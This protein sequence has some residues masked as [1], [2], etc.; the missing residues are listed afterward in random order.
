MPDTR[1]KK[2]AGNSDVTTVDT[3]VDATVDPT[4]APTVDATVV[5]TVVSTEVT[6]V[7]TGGASP[8]SEMTEVSSGAATM[9]A[10]V[11]V[12]EQLSGVLSSMA[13]K[14]E[15]VNFPT[16]SG[17]EDSNVTLFVSKVDRI[18]I[19]GA[20]REEQVLD[21]LYQELTGSAKVYL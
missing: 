15:P 14:N 12:M 3:T 7:S 17:D 16:F 9:E 13:K 8:V 11:P 21:R 18:L 5:T 6:G 4:V 2:T 20:L 19:S 1:S 10:I